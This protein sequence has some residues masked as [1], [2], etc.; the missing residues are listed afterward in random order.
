M[1]LILEDAQPQQRWLKVVIPAGEFE[2]LLKHVTPEDGEKFS[3]RMAHLGLVKQ[4]GEPTPGKNADYLLEVAK[5]YVLDWRGV[6]ETH[7][8]PEIPYKPE[9][10]VGVMRQSIAA[11]TLIT[12]TI[13]R[14]EAFFVRN[15]DGPS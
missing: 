3:R 13:M 2:V 15:G 8:G 1:G 9:A 7:D 6:R 12:E 4:N 5:A 14:E 11:L 10:L